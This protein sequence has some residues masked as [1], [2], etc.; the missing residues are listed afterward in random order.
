MPPSTET[1]QRSRAV[2]DVPLLRFV[3][4]ELVCGEGDFWQIALSPTHDALNAAGAVHG[5]V[6]STV[7]D[8]AAYLAVLPHLSWQEEAVTVALAVS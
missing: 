7:L 1:D 4:A 2:L 6:I 8:V 3:G 5:G